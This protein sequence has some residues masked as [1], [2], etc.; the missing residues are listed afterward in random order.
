MRTSAMDASHCK[1]S[2][3][4]AVKKWRQGFIC[5]YIGITLGACELCEC[6]RMADACALILG[7]VVRVELGKALSTRAPV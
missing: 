5:R 4:A 3:I 7:P 2:D 6:I 1:G